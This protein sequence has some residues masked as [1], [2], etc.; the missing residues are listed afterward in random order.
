MACET[1]TDTPIDVNPVNVE[2]KDNNIR[3]TENQHTS[4][5]A[6]TGFR[7]HTLVAPSA[8]MPDPY[9]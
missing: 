1:T 4:N 9:I 5:R 7:A 2:I 6:K 3:P 8:S